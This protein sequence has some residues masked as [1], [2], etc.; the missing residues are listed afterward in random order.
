MRW[1]WKVNGRGYVYLRKQNGLTLWECM[2]KGFGRSSNVFV[3]VLR[4]CH[5]QFSSTQDSH[6]D[7]SMSCVCIHFGSFHGKEKQANGEWG[8]SKL[9]TLAYIEPWHVS[10]F[11]S[12]YFTLDVCALM[13]ALFVFALEI[14]LTHFLCQTGKRRRWAIIIIV[15]VFNSECKS[16]HKVRLNIVDSLGTGSHN[17]HTQ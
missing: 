12:L 15:V 3:C 14:L 11:L 10:D 6:L 17:I 13:Y 8:E 1:E 9:S 16:Y 7:E 2:R 4:L 5:P